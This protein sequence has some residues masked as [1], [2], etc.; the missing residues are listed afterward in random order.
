MEIYSMAFLMYTENA[1]TYY[2]TD[3]ALYFGVPGAE[4]INTAHFPYATPVARFEFFNNRGESI[5]GGATGRTAPVIYIR[6]TTGFDSNLTQ[7]WQSVQAF[8]AAYAGQTGIDNAAKAFLSSNNF[9][10]GANLLEAGG[11]SAVESITRQILNALVGVAGFAA[12]AGAT[13]KAQAEFLLRRMVN[14]FQQLAYAGPVFRRFQPTFTFRPTSEEEAVAMNKIIA[15]FRIASSPRTNL[16]NDNATVVAEGSATEQ[17]RLAREAEGATKNLTTEQK[18][19]QNIAAQ[20]DQTNLD[21][22][23]TA[24]EEKDTGTPLTF[25]YPDMVQYSIYLA[26]AGELQ[27][28]FNTELCMIENVSLQYGSQGK[29]SFFEQANDGKFYP[30][31]VTMTLSLQESVLVT[32]ERAASDYSA[33]TVIY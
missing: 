27:L 32:A 19:Q 9:G 1:G 8:G 10:I 2:P 22:N 20:I 7:G 6:F 21:L 3:D 14:N 26:F 33:N 30:T 4:N 24:L 29:F 12:G 16:S 17:E 15:S 11:K 13:G 31:E 25:I 23:K 28:L 5:S 18:Q